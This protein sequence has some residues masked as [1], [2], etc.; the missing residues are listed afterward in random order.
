MLS[1]W[2]PRIGSARLDFSHAASTI[3]AYFG[4]ISAIF[5]FSENG[6]RRIAA[7]SADGQI[8]MLVRDD[9]GPTRHMPSTLPPRR[10]RPRRE[11]ALL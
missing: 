7:G 10:Y 8:A 5:V 9:K 11:A 2:V 3:C 1:N 4:C 6:E